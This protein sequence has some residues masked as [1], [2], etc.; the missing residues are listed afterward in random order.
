MRTSEKLKSI[1]K[2][3]KTG[4]LLAIFIILSTLAV[5]YYYKHKIS[6]LSNYNLSS[7]QALQ[8][9]Y[10]AELHLRTQIQEWKNI[11]I[12]GHNEKEYTHYLHAMKTQASAFREKIEALSALL[13]LHKRLD[14][15]IRVQIEAL[16]RTQTA[17]EE[18]YLGALNAYSLKE[19]LAYQRIDALVRGKDREIPDQIK[20][21][22][23]QL[24]DQS[25]AVRAKTLHELKN[26]NFAVGM[27]VFIALLVI[28][29]TTRTREELSQS[30]TMFS[31]IA[32]HTNDGMVVFE[33]GKIV[34]ESPGHI[35]IIGRSLL[36]ADKKQI[37]A[38]LHP[39]DVEEVFTRFNEAIAEHKPSLLTHYRALHVNGHYIHKEDSLSFEYDETGALFRTYVIVRDVTNEA[40]KDTKIAQSEERY[41]TFVELSSDII[42][43]KDSQ[44]N[45]LI[46]NKNLADFM[47]KSVEGLIGH[48][49]FELLPYEAAQQ[50]RQSD[51]HSLE[52]GQSVVS[53]EAI[54]GRI[55]ETTKYP[56]LFQGEHCIAGVIRDIT[57]RNKDKEQIYQLAYY[58]PLTKLPNRRLFL[59]R[60]EH[61]VE[62]AKHNALFGGIL[63]IDV[64]HFKIINDT[65][66]HSEGDA[67]LQMIKERL[68]AILHPEDTLAHLG[69]DEFMMMCEGC[70]D[71]SLGVAQK[72]VERSEQI[73]HL[74]SAPYLLGAMEYR[75]TVSIGATLL[76]PSHK[77]ASTLM[78]EVEIALHHAKDEGRN[79][80]CFFE[81]TMQEKVSQQFLLEGALRKGIENN[82]FEL[83][84]QS[85]VDASMHLLGAEALI[86][87]HHEG[88]LVPPSDFI[89]LLES[90]GL[91]VDV[92]TWVIEEGCKT[93]EKW[94]QEP[95]KA[96]LTLA[97]NVS[98]KQ[99]ADDGFVSS[100][101]I[102]LGR[103]R[104][105]PSRLK[106]ELT[107]N[108]F[109]DNT[110][111]S[112]DKMNLIRSLGIGLSL[113]DFGTGYASLSYLKR[114]PITQLKIDQSFVRDVLEDENDAMIIRM[115]IG[116]AHQLG[117]GLIAEG[118]ETY[119]Q[120]QW[121]HVNHCE[122]FQ[123]YYIDK[124]QT[125][126]MFEK[127]WE[128]FN[129]FSHEH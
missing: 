19:P 21:L 101:H 124:P 16:L 85:Q 55:F 72:I 86:R 113:D 61:A 3:S 126:A 104:F 12:R 5:T 77:S 52:L 117:V 8:I 102:I 18:A 35:R 83:Y 45:Y 29:Y 23:A 75:C 107:E 95:S 54:H 84:Y 50:C 31:L 43:L 76:E 100:L 17:L 44:F 106:I 13:R 30:T 112:I 40:I 96:H 2:L 125:L 89:P 91:I 1:N 109:L 108:L 49:D 82:A 47:G 27:S 63:L 48:S 116:V 97:I 111:A 59:D 57:E 78:K 6:S 114:I 53:E 129:G 10:E 90:T 15:P 121:L 7:F 94:S 68:N 11:L 46:V 120:L 28:L 51:M 34:Y 56:L 80:M 60:L 58:H 14:K 105:D 62:N 39:E 4:V 9:T 93:L 70:S 115:I 110:Q 65:W 37:Y 32:E 73:G 79:R 41:R 81:N 33:K 26:M 22:N 87:W 123:G 74:L 103:Y 92:G 66:G 25:K 98:P 128:H 20:A 36:G 122:S 71:S 88:R 64:D 127:R 42:F 24:L 118:V 69:S 99:F 119:E 38:L 67:L